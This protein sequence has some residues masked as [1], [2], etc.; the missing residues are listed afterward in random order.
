MWFLLIKILTLEGFFLFLLLL[1]LKDHS[2]L[3]HFLLFHPHL[4]SFF[5]FFFYSSKASRLLPNQ[6]TSAEL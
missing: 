2:Q 5:F 3:C 6:P 4:C 1:P